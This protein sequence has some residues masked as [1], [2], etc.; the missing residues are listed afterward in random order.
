MIKE[1]IK[2]KAIEIMRTFSPGEFKRFADFVNS[3]CYNKSKNVVKMY[4]IIR[5]NFSTGGGFNLTKEDLYDR[6]YPG[7]KYN[8]IVMRILMSDLLKLA[9]EFLA[10]VNY[11][12]SFI[13]SKWHLLKQLQIRRL[14]SLFMKN[15]KETE[16]MLEDQQLGREFYYYYKHAIESIKNNF[17]L[18]RD[19]QELTGEVMLKK[20][21]CIAFYALIDLLIISEGLRSNKNAYNTNYPVNF[22]DEFL[23][24]VDL[25]RIINYLKKNLPDYY[26][27][28][29]IFYYLHYT[30]THDEDE[31]YYFEAK[32]LFEKRKDLF[33]ENEKILLYVKLENCCKE[34]RKTGSDLFLKELFELYKTKIKDGLLV[35][36]RRKYLNITHCRDILVTAVELGEFDWCRKFMRENIPKLDPAYQPNM[37]SYGNALL[38]FG[39]GD[40]EGALVNIAKVKYDYFI[41]KM[42]VKHLMSKIYYELN[43]TEEAFS[44]LDTFR[45]FLQ[46]NRSVS[47]A[48][49]QYNLNFIRGV[50]DLLNYR[51]SG[52]ND[53]SDLIGRIEKL[54]NVRSK[55]WLLKKAEELMK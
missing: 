8:D 5:K 16:K 21:E 15:L 34:K 23:N 38:L 22:T 10:Q 29:A 32:Q 28:I 20:G 9:E 43:Y 54:G 31:K 6:L 2:N 44:L 42:D 14:D 12:T 45:H 39:E 7:K 27:V 37:M 1:T 19:K 55:R 46:K 24:S 49:K 3:P 30:F 11:S 33:N 4:D 41:F 52:N 53:G 36:P 50:H 51:V 47:D 35:L 25:E 18:A 17:Y 48:F 26:P 40:F 13:F